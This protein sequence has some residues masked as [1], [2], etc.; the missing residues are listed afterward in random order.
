MDSHHSLHRRPPCGFDMAFAILVFAAKPP[1]ASPIRMNLNG[2]TATATADPVPGTIH[3][4]PINQKHWKAWKLEFLP[5]QANPVSAQKAAERLRYKP[6]VALNVNLNI[7]SPAFTLTMDNT[8]AGNTCRR[9][10]LAM[11]ERCFL[12]PP[13][14]LPVPAPA[15]GAAHP[16]AS[17]GNF[18]QLSTPM[19]CG[20]G[21]GGTGCVC[22]ELRGPSGSVR[23]PIRL[24]LLATSPPS[25]A[26]RVAS[27]RRPRPPFLP[28]L[29]HH[30][31]DFLHLIGADLERQPLIGPAQH[32]SSYGPYVGLIDLG[33]HGAPPSPSS[34]QTTT[35]VCVVRRRSACHRSADPWPRLT[36]RSQA[37]I[38]APPAPNSPAYIVLDDEA[39]MEDLE[40]ATTAVGKTRS[41][42]RRVK[43][44][45]FAADPPRLSH[46]CVH[47]PRMTTKFDFRGRP[48][49]LHAEDNLALISIGFA[50]GP[51]TEYHLLQ[52]C[53][54]RAA[55]I[56][57]KYLGEQSFVAS[58]GFRPC[59]GDGGGYVVAALA[60]TLVAEESELHVFRSERGTWTKT[61][62]AHGRHLLCMV[63]KLGFVTTTPR[64]VFVPLPKLLPANKDHS[65]LCSARPFRD[66]A[67]YA[68]GL[69]KCV[70]VEPLS[71]ITIPQVDVEE[72]DMVER[73][74]L[75]EPR[76]EGHRLEQDAF[77]HLLAQECLIH[78]DDIIANTTRTRAALVG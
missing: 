68:D 66:V 26:A 16:A 6:D 58:V 52:G 23:A 74:D 43:V 57:G 12:P 7:A 62:L 8:T 71:R 32:K 60:L 78:V 69:I 5:S 72:V 25:S 28:R 14:F 31:L 46:F 76:L 1:A 10:W 15:A 27:S 64:A 73:R 20:G 63:E 55:A 30:T 17:P 77:F 59:G 70:E 33:L 2:I 13:A 44:S 3:P 11:E 49:V 34:S 24:S 67:G 37:P 4:T 22:A 9:T 45:F 42:H 65:E 40:N 35:V 50:C 48:R 51:T 39:Y 38:P 29:H 75:R 53:R 56:V 19:S 21:G 61:V 18:F 36:P 54:A 41:G 47:C